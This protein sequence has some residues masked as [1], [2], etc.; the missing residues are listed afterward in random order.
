MDIK[1]L[2]TIKTNVIGK[3]PVEIITH[4]IF[5]GKSLLSYVILAVT[6]YVMILTADIETITAKEQTSG[7]S[8]YSNYQIDIRISSII[9]VNRPCLYPN[10]ALNVRTHTTEI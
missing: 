7:A 5:L 1:Q 3:I 6:L 8:Y 2:P 10:K 4:N 9:A